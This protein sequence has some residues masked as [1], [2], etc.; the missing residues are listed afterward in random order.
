MLSRRGFLLDVGCLD[1]NFHDPV[2]TMTKIDILVAG[3]ATRRRSGSQTGFSLIELM[4]AMA[5]G[6][7]LVAVVGILLL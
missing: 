2:R 7:F 6:L 3:S 4:V 1:S 5:I